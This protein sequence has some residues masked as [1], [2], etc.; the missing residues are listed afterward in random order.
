[1]HL[2]FAVHPSPHVLSPVGILSGAL[3]TRPIFVH[4]TLVCKTVGEP[5]C[6]KA[7]AVLREDIGELVALVLLKPNSTV[8]GCLRDARHESIDIFRYHS[9]RDI[10]G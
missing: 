1:M 4:C 2:I 8:W 5:V 9:R 7:F 10:K 3:P 6:D